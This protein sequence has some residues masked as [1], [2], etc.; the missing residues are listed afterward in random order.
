MTR[1]RKPP[2]LIRKRD[3]IWTVTGPHNRELLAYTWGEALLFALAAGHP[4]WQE[5]TA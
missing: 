2:W 3:G 5:P 1:S 4:E